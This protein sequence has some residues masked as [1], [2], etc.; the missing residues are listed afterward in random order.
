MLSLPQTQDKNFWYDNLR[1]RKS[2]TPPHSLNTSVLMYLLYPSKHTEMTFVKSIPNILV[3]E[4]MNN[5]NSQLPTFQTQMTK[6][7]WR[8]CSGNVYLTSLGI[9]LGYREYGRTKKNPVFWLTEDSIMKLADCILSKVTDLIQ[10]SYAFR[11][12]VGGGEELPNR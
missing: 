10:C 3:R 6:N 2:P 5:R 4:R 7:R 12:G 9:H 11:R 1:T 8:C